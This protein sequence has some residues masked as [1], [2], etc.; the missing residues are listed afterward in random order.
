MN[1]VLAVLGACFIDILGFIVAALAAS[2]FIHV[3]FLG[4]A[5][6]ESNE[7]PMLVTG[8]IF[9]VPFVALFVAYFAFVPTLPV[10]L[11]GELLSRRDWLFYALGGVFVGLAISALFWRAALPVGG[12]LNPDAPAVAP[13]YREAGF[14]ALLIA[15]GVVGGLAYWLVAGRLSG[16][17]RSR[18]APSPRV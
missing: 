6:F 15:A 10:I 5:G 4:S 13:I 16:S 18:A 1:R 12:G 9:S 11:L 7:A 8:S 3:M 17:W 14:F 2:A